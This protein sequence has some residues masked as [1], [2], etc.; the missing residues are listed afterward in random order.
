MTKK[1]YT[2]ECYPNDGNWIRPLGY[3]HTGDIREAD[4]V[5]FG[6]GADITPETYGEEPGPHTGCS[7]AR[8]KGEKRDF[9][10]ARTLDIP[11]VGICRGLN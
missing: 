3:E 6:G 10:I 8:E 7:P 11:C 2:S 9:A 1:Y 5:I 4:V